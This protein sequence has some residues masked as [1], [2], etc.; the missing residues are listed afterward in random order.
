MEVFNIRIS[1]KSNKFKKRNNVLVSETFS[2]FEGQCKKFPSILIALFCSTCKGFI[3]FQNV[4]RYTT[5][6]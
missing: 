2:S 4:S 5:E 3:C 6:Q 1:F